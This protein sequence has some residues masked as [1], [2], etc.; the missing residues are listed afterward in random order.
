MAFTAPKVLRL[1]WPLLL[2][3]LLLGAFGIFAI[4]VLEF[5]SF[6]GTLIVASVVPL[7]LIGGVTALWITGYSLS[8]TGAIGFIALIGM[9]IKNSILLV[10][11]TNQLRAQGVPLKEAIERAG[12]TR[13]LPIVL[14]TATALGA[15]LPL[16][17]QGSGLYSP[18]AI[19]IIGGLI[20]S[21]LLSRVVTPVV[22][23]L[24]PP[25]IPVSEEPTPAITP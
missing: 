13:F 9:E 4:L 22:Y 5:G 11:F 19:V 6:R 2:L 1:N 8:F 10:D 14:T 21:L 18:L 17:M 23:S 3:A 15:L 7:G 12:E 25:A 16:A 24:L 20:S